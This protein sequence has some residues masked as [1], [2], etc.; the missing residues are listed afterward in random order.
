MNLH[1]VFAQSN[2]CQR[3]KLLEYKADRLYSVARTEQVSLR[4]TG[5]VGVGVGDGHKCRRELQI[6]ANRVPDTL[7]MPV[8][9]P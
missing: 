9:H 3:P 4:G 2:S 6:W 7:G 1:V 5:M 8:S